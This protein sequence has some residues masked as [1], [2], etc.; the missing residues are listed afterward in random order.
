MFSIVVPTFLLNPSSCSFSLIPLL[1]CA[2]CIA[3]LEHRV[4]A[5]TSSAFETDFLFFSLLYHFFFSFS[6]LLYSSEMHTF[7]YLFIER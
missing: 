7:D 4:L 1:H 3:G 5:F 6:F 2:V